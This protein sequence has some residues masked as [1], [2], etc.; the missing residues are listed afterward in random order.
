MDKTLLYIQ[1]AEYIHGKGK[2]DYSLLKNITKRNCN[3]DIIC[4]K[5]G[6]FNQSLHKHISGDG[7]KKCSSE[8]RLLKIKLNMESDFYNK[9]NDIHNNKYD[10]SKVEYINAK[11]NIIIICPSHG[12]FN[13]SPNHHLSGYGCKKCANEN[14]SKRLKIS[15][16]EYIKDLINI[17]NNK[18]D[19]SK[20]N[21]KGVEDKIIVN[22]PSHGDFEIRPADHKS[23]RGCKK[24]SKENKIMY[25]K[26]TTD[27]FINKSIGIHGSKYDYSKVIYQGALKYVTIIC[28][29]HGEFNQ[30][31]S[32]HYKY[33]CGKC[34][35]E[36]NSN[37]IKLLSNCKNN[38]IS[39]SILQHNN[40]YDY[41]KSVYINSSTKLII[42][43]NTH[44]DF[45][46]TPNNHL[47]GKG[48]PSCGIIRSSI[49]KIKSFEYYYKLFIDRHDYKYTY[50]NV[51]WINS[52]TKIDVTCKK[53]GEF[54]ILPY[55][56]KN[57]RG[58]PSCTNQYSKKSIEWLKYLSIK[59]NISIQ[60]AE[61]IGEKII[62]GKTKADGYCK[63]NNTVYE[64]HGNFWHG[65]PKLY[66]H[67]EINPKTGTKFGILLKKTLHKE[68]IIRKLGF[69]Y[70]CIWETEWDNFIKIL[71]KIQLRIK[72]R[73]KL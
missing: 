64:F 13:Q 66:D 18:Y 69:N 43:C 32:N 20:V 37:N 22:C 1:K 62:Y 46:I 47:R 3:V 31:P 52:S 50:E 16:N 70:V 38:F 54:K 73:R 40:K 12:E 9:A 44:G 30:T 61:N 21:W 17:H 58:C 11:T 41:S 14:T 15:W 34:G 2:Y 59:H 42:T 33:G 49:S 35:N 45:N 6:I 63:E 5:H 65:N 53:H 67:E 28:K 72:K 8:N 27:T 56:H 4:I 60:Q 25:N 7:C 23:G 10:Y 68:L 55:D 19:Y 48:C 51:N 24:C 57:G 26:L 39:K 29:K 71:K 36:N